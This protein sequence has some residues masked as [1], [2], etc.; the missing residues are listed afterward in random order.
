MAEARDVSWVRV[1]ENLRWSE[2]EFD[3][4]WF[5]GRLTPRPYVLMFGKWARFMPY[6]CDCAENRRW[7]ERGRRS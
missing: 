5:C 2:T 3:E 4:C 7:I 1:P 6:P